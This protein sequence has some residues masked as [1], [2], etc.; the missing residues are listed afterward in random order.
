MAHVGEIVFIG[1]HMERDALLHTRPSEKTCI[2]TP[3]LP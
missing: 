1:E 3:D 2:Q